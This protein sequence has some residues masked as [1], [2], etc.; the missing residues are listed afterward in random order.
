MDLD[1]WN[2]FGHA[3]TRK[4]FLSCNDFI[5]WKSEFQT[6][7]KFNSN[8]EFKQALK[9]D[10]SNVTKSRT[11]NNFFM[12]TKFWHQIV[13]E[14]IYAFCASNCFNKNLIYKSHHILVWW[15]DLRL[16]VIEK[17]CKSLWSFKIKAYFLMH[18]TLLPSSNPEIS[19]L[20]TRIQSCQNCSTIQSDSTLILRVLLVKSTRLLSIYYKGNPQYG[21]RNTK[22]LKN[23][24][25]NLKVYNI[26]VYYQWKLKYPLSVHI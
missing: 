7:L 15:K 2:F 6:F 8:F 10:K 26:R 23:Q 12:R 25:Q 17:T 11:T 5:F 13:I 4:T 18:S 14:F 22:K 3:E 24:Y 16:D 21:Q 9:A 19:L 1:N 20:P